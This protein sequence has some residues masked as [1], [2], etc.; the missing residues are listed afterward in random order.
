MTKFD[1]TLL[2]K[3]VDLDKRGFSQYSRCT[4]QPFTSD[5]F[6]A[7]LPHLDEIQT[8]STFSD[9]G[10]PGTGSSPFSNIQHVHNVRVASPKQQFLGD[11]NGHCNFV[12]EPGSL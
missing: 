10:L 1:A 2:Q 8:I 7:S 6:A 4:Y 12:G 11:Q 5:S 9:H 3:R